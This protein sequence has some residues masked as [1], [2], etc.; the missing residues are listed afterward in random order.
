MQLTNTSWEKMEVSATTEKYL[1][2]THT[3]WSRI[4]D[5]KHIFTVRLKGETPNDMDGGYFSI[6]SALIVKG[7]M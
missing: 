4:L 7:M 2:G 5:G 3:L 1:R 6:D